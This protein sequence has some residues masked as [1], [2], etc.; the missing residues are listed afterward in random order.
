LRIW[1]GGLQG[2]R[3]EWSICCKSKQLQLV[4]F[5]WADGREF[6]MMVGKEGNTV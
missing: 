6:V 3:K 4:N 5:R 2:R 1:G